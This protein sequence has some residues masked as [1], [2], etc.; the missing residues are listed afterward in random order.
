MDF[1][2]SEEQQDIQKLAQQIIADISTQ[3]HLKELEKAGSPG[4]DV[5]WAAM[6]EAGLLGVP[7]SEAV[8]G[9]GFDFESLSLVLEELGRHASRAPAIPVLVSAGL[10][11]QR[12]CDIETQKRLLTD[13]VAGKSLITAARIEPGNEDPAAPETTA[14]ASGDGFVINGSKHLVSCAD[15]AKGIVLAAKAGN[16]LVIVLIDPTA[17]GVTLTPQVVTSEEVQFQL[18]LNNVEVAADA[19]LARGE[20]AEKWI[21]WSEQALKAALCAMAVGVCDKMMRMAGSYTSEREQFG[22]PIATFQAVSHR[23]ADCYIDIECLRL[24]TQQAVSLISMDRDASDAVNVAK[25]WCGDVTHRVSQSAQHVHGGIGVDRDYGMHRYCLLAREIELTGG[26][27]AGVLETF[28]RK[29]L[30]C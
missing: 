27:S 26:A 12:Y 4:D 18:D 1:S 15:R 23:V 2:L 7:F 20:T 9:M 16:E 24:V 28:A 22:R 29:F 14:K 13:V 30:A 8:G 25:V 17:K 6:A 3:D 5:L 19:V 11:I 10:P 21:D